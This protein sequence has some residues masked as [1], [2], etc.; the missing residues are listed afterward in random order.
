VSQRHRRSGCL[1]EFG[2]QKKEKEKHTVVFFLRSLPRPWFFD[3][4]FST[5]RW[6]NAEVGIWDEEPWK[7]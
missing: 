3:P 6:A 5:G 1:L 4:G 7:N 2:V